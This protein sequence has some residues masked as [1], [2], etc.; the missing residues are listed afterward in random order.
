MSKKPKVS[1]VAVTYNQERYIREA[2]DSFLAQKVDFSIEII[3]AD[4]YSTDNTPKIISEYA[5]NHPDIFKPILAKKNIGVAGNFLR[6]MQ[7]AKGEYIA[8]CEGDDFWTDPSKLQIQTDFMD[9][10]ADY[11]VCFHPVKVFSEGKDK[12]HIYPDDKDGARFTTKELLKKNFIQTNSVMYRRQKYVDIPLNV[13]PVD[14]YLHLYHA[15]FGKI[16]FINKVMAAYRRHPGGV[17]WGSDTNID[18]IWKKHSLAHL[19]LYAEFIKFYGDNKEYRQIIEK[20]VVDIFKTILRIDKQYG[21]ELIMQAVRQ[22][23]NSTEMYIKTQHAQ[24]NKLE[25]TV[26]ERDTEI[27]SLR[28]SLIGKDQQIQILAHELHMIKLSRVWK[29]RNAVASIVGKKVIK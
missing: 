18:E 2:L 24:L 10:Y 14:W 21:K 23:P 6:G 5:K 16:G 4:D 12:D 11:A 7:A 9:T 28:K 19:A 20:H 27:T 26:A 13:L 15:Q 25:S 29:Y 8:L 3:V 17:W 1:V 22:F